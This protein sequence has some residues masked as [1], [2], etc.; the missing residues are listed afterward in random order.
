M[1]SYAEALASACVCSRLALVISASEQS[2]SKLNTSDSSTFSIVKNLMNK[3]LPD[4][5]GK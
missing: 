1:L 5:V 4:F 3:V 2:T